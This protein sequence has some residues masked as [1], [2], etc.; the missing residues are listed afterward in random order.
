MD[1][2]LKISDAAAAAQKALKSNANIRLIA[3]RLM[4]II[5]VSTA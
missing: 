3:D 5:A 4:E 1:A 2:I